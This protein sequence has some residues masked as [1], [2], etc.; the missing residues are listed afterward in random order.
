MTD[1]TEQAAAVE[2]SL[3]T[4]GAARVAT[5]AR[6][7]PTDQQDLWH[8]C[9][10]PE[11]LARWFAPVHGDL[12]PGGRYQVEGNAGGTVETC[13]APHGFTATWEFDG[14][15][16]RI[17]VRLTPLD[18][19]RTRLELEHAG[20]IP[21]EFWTQ[22]GPGATGIGWDLSFLGLARHLADPAA[23]R[24]TDDA[25]ATTPEGIAF[26]TASGEAWREVAVA[27][28]DDPAQARAAADRC[29]AFYTGA[30][31]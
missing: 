21:E 9:T 13:D 6:T 11:R 25:M 31:A 23:P 4:R 16:S 19:G 10:T 26:I 8:A 15:V 27:A 7:Y 18:A 22:F 29:R 24:P 17:S 28:G 20:E 14:Q 1:H 30:P 12:R 2:R 5:I 3:G